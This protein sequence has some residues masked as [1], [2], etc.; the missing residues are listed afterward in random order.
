MKTK[1]QNETNTQIRNKDKT[2]NRQNCT[3][4]CATPTTELLLVGTGTS[5]KSANKTEHQGA[6]K[7]KN[8][9]S[10]KAAPAVCGTG[11]LAGVY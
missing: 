1:K 2:E 10:F 5:G 11:S 4:R 3:S 7:N 9:K 6:K 8:K